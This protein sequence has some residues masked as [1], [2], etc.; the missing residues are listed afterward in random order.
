MLSK[1]LLRFPV[2]SST[3]SGIEMSQEN[4]NWRSMIYIERRCR[5]Y[6]I[7]ILET[8]CIN[9][10]IKFLVFNKSCS[11]E[12]N[13]VYTW[14]QQL[15]QIVHYTLQMNIILSVEFSSC[16]FVHPGQPFLFGHVQSQKYWRISFFFFSIVWIDSGDFS[17]LLFPE[18]VVISRLKWWN[19]PYLSVRPPWIY[20]SHIVTE[21]NRMTL[22]VFPPWGIL[23]INTL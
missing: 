21:K 17:V 13:I 23:L 2:C 5:K 3:L 10:K 8:I 12:L 6:I 15:E 22:E 11:I 18:I 16:S 7:T 4:Y 14:S 20:S 19:L 9:A 1:Y